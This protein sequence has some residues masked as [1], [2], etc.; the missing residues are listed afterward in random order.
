MDS[1]SSDY[2]DH[3]IFNMN[4]RLSFEEIEIE[5]EIDS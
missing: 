3:G 2:I 1:E 5:I 4:S